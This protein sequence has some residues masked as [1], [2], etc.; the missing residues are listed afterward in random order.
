MNIYLVGGAV[1][2]QLL[3]YPSTERDWVVVGASPK[4][5]L[6]LGYAQ[7]GKDFP[8]FLHP[9]TKE[10][11][12]LARTERKTGPGYAGFSFD[13]TTDVTLEQDLARRDL[14]INAIAQADDGQLIDPFNGQHDIET[15][16]LRHVSDAFAED[17][18]RILRIARFAA[19]YHHLGF[20]VAK[21][22][23]TLMRAM[24][25]NGE[26][27]ALVPERVWKETARALCEQDPQV[28]IEV[29]RDCGALAR[30]MPELD[31]L[32]GVPQP[33]EHHPEIDTGVHTLM[34]LRHAAQTSDDLCIRFATLVHDLGKG[35]TPE[36][37]L[38][39]HHGH[40]QSGLAAVKSLCRRL[41][42]PNDCKRLALAVC[43]F[44]THCHR[45]FELNP[46][47]LNKLFNH[48]GAYKKPRLLEDFLQCCEADA[49]GRTGFETRDY[50]QA[51]YL[52]EALASCAD[53]SAA[54][55]MAKGLQGPA[56][57]EAMNNARVK[58]LEHFKKHYPNS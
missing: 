34:S 17:P 54:E 56:I 2:D 22:T 26:V 48:F 15:K 47:T 31:T 38:P 12:A 30:I 51:N 18:V 55:F 52:R 8:V 27:D 53:I 1:R 39:R 57:G 11:Y 4:D 41:G 19:R 16:T 32:F 29:L 35:R 45:A 40:E 7:V 5:M 9:K 42:V 50:P 33:A 44:H 14:T 49:K 13:T 43:E 23:Q 6:A 37:L 58:R 10:E 28:F 21:E 20:C 25:D 36:T 24:V 46:K 3:N